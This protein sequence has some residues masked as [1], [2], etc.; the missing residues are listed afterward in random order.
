MSYKAGNKVF[1]N[2]RPEEFGT[3]SWNIFRWDHDNPT[4]AECKVVLTD[5]FRRIDLDFDYVGW[6]EYQ[7]RLTK[8]DTLIGE[9]ESFK[10]AMIESWKG[11]EQ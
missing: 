11:G 1:L 5:C 10:A 9:L 6:S 3:V 4:Q 8:V 2:D 7:E